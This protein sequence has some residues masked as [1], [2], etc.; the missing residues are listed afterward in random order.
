MELSAT[1]TA[2][3]LNQAS[4]GRDA[5]LNGATMGRYLSILE[6]SLLLHRMKPY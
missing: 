6:T 2:Q 3:V 4:L 1:R 5:G